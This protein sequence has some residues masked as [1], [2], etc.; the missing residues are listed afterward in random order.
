MI[1]PAATIEKIK[2]ILNYSTDIRDE[3]ESL[4]LCT[5]DGHEIACA[6]YR[7]LKIE[8]AKVSAMA[9]SFAGLS[10]TIA[11]CCNKQDALGGI[12]ETKDGLIICGLIKTPE[13][14]LV[15]LG[16]FAKGVQHG[17]ALW[18]FRNQLNKFR[19]LLES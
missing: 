16:V 12:V 17:L 8:E 15:L 3:I 4:L 1:L 10:L 18:N 13:V 19:S 5:S 14:D 6:S 7:G 2:E 9:A 11:D